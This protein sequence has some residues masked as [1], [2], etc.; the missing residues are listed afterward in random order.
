MASIGAYVG[1]FASGG[2]R[3]V[4]LATTTAVVVASVALFLTNYLLSSLFLWLNW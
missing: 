2:A 3:G 4:G 1:Y